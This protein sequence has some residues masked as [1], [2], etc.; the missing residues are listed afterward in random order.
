M[1][2]TRGRAGLS[3]DGVTVFISVGV[4]FLTVRCRCKMHRSWQPSQEV[5]C[6]PIRHVIEMS[7]ETLDRTRR[8]P[9]A[10]SQTS[11]AA[12]PRALGWSAAPTT[13][14]GRSSRAPAARAG[15]TGSP[16]LPRAATTPSTRQRSAGCTRERREGR[17]RHTSTSRSGRRSSTGQP[18]PAA[19]G[20][21][22]VRG[23]GAT[24]LGSAGPWSSRNGG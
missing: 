14:G 1:A 6:G 12:K 8:T 21:S 7:S 24:P 9:V 17:H 5:A 10:S 4:T 15:P 18:R 23:V 11:P 16:A 20:A 22:G 2:A 3:V 19:A 13:R